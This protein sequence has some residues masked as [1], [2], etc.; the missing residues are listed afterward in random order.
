MQ[1]REFLSQVIE[2]EK[3]KSED[4]RDSAVPNKNLFIVM[5]LIKPVYTENYIISPKSQQML[6]SS[7][8]KL[9]KTQITNELGIYGVLVR[10]LLTFL[11]LKCLN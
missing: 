7:Q 6:A 8:Q 4:E 2:E 10:L 5:D 3:N 9:S 1:N 11:N